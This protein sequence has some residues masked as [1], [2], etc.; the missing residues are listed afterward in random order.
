MGRQRDLP[1]G[2]GVAER[3]DRAAVPGH[4]RELHIGTARRQVHNGAGV[5]DGKRP[6]VFGN[7]RRLAG[8]PHAGVHRLREER[9]APHEQELIVPHNGGA[10]IW[11]YPLSA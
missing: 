11:K 9:P 8:K 4:P 6:G 10:G 1:I 7:R 5:R 2:L 3:C